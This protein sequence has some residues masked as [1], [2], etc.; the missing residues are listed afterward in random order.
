MA[1]RFR[2]S[3][4]KLERTKG[5]A[6][7]RLADC[8]ELELRGAR[9]ARAG[10]PRLDAGGHLLIDFTNVERLGAA[11]LSALLALHRAARDAGGRLS[12]FNLSRDV[13]D[14]FLATGLNAVLEICRPEPNRSAGG[15]SPTRRAL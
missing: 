12:L 10:S 11:E 1:T 2:R 6:V 7:L 9:T 3:D 5:L 8:A 14:V 4:A 15:T 13:Y